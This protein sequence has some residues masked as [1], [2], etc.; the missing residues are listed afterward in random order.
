[1]VGN[2]LARARSLVRR[3]LG[4]EGVEVSRLLRKDL[5]RLTE[6]IERLEESQR[7]ATELARRADRTSMQVQHVSVL[8]RRQQQLIEKLPI[9]LDEKCIVDHVR[10][11]VAAAPLLTDPYEHAIVERVLPD[12]VYDL[13]ISA[14]PPVAFFDDKD[15]IKQNLWFPLEYGPTLSATAWEFMDDVIAR[16]AI[17]PAVLEK[18]HEPLQRH[19]ASMFGTAFTERANQLP[20]SAFGGRLMLRRPGYHLGP[21]R[22]P[23]RSMLTCLLYLAR[24]GDSDTYGTKI[25]RVVDDEEAGY[26]QTYYPEQEGRT[27]ELVKVVPFRRNTMLVSLNSR[28]AHG[29]TISPDAPADLERYTYQFYVAPLK[30]A[31]SALLKSLP[32]AQRA[33]WR[34]KAKVM[35]EHA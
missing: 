18:F 8:N 9:L 32:A 27:C 11:A 20:Q 12:D 4:R 21:H 31:L 17:R 33:K 30:E 23:K 6:R 13:L 1:M 5:H 22:D 34:S 15:P 19:F 2:T 29:A 24:D 14:I 7:N 35:P 28:G 25:F 10:R 3:F 16:R 26:K